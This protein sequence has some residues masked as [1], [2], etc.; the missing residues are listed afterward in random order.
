[1]LRQRCGTFQ[2]LE[3]KGTGAS[4]ASVASGVRTL[5]TVDTEG[6]GVDARI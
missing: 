4:G 6:S 5:R 3:Q 2:K 1:M